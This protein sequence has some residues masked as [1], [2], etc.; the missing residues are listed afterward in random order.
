MNLIDGKQIAWQIKDETK[1][2]VLELKKQGIT[3]A[4]AVILVGNDQASKVYVNNKKKACEYVG[5][6]SLSH[7]LPEATSEDE[8][9][10]LIED[11]NNNAAVH[12]ILVQ[13]PLPK[14]I[15]EQKILLRIKPEKDVDCFHPYN[16]GLLNIGTGSLTPCTPSGIIELLRRS[17]ITIE[18]KN[19][20][21][22][23]RSNIVGKP[24][25]TMLLNEN[26]TVTTA[27]SRTADLKGVC[28]NADIIV[29]AVGKANFLTPDMVKDGAVL[30][31][32]GM[33]RNADGKL[34]GD[35][36]FDGCKEK[37]S[38]ITPVPGG[39][40]PM[41][42]AMLMKNCVSACEALTGGN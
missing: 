17:G 22:I 3:P 40:G 2:R 10:G 28:L 1:N 23:G 34:C 20:L 27:H 24:V 25:S 16:V 29:A 8:L 14:H 35:I 15:D 36:D 11:L 9:L 38:W 6:E 13:L 4:L 37:A 26:G 5:I 18:G 19:C 7:E 33:N 31:D 12:G 32:V 39:V 30:I 21:V 41:T 42:I